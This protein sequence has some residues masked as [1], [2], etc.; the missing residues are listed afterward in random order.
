[1]AFRI[2]IQ[3]WCCKY[4]YKVHSVHK[5]E[6]SAQDISSILLEIL[7]ETRKNKQAYLATGTYTLI[8][9]YFIFLKFYCLNIHCLRNWLLGL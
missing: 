7:R 3:K 1:M 6:Y 9:H 2:R 4:E 8:S 5:R